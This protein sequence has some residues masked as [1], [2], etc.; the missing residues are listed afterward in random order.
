M[1]DIKYIMRTQYDIYSLSK[2]FYK[3]LTNIS[4]AIVRHVYLT[5]SL[6]IATIILLFK[7]S[8]THAAA[9]ASGLFFITRIQR[10]HANWHLSVRAF[11]KS[12]SKLK[13]RVA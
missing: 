8:S 12:P 10:F 1:M 9:S 2:H 13:N 4:T 7:F 5:K 6:K 3:F 11:Y